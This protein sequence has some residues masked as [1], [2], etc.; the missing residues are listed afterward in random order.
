MLKR[1]TILVVTLLLAYLSYAVAREVG[2]W[3]ELSAQAVVIAAS[4]GA[5]LTAALPGYLLTRLL[6]SSALIS[7][8]EDFEG[9]CVPLWVNR[10]SASYRD[11]GAVTGL[12]QPVRKVPGV[13]LYIARRGH[14][15]GYFKKDGTVGSPSGH[16]LG[17]LDG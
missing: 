3:L 11:V 14:F 8:V 9:Q 13:P 12:F 17:H 10:S 16:F 2:V 7:S 15:H 4:L 6:Y 5:L 1:I